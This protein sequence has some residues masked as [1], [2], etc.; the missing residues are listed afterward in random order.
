MNSKR[1]ASPR[2][3]AP[4]RAAGVGPATVNVNAGISKQ[5]AITERV[6]FKVE[7]SF[8]NVFNHTNL[9]DP[10]LNIADSTAGVITSARG[11]DFGGART[12]NRHP[13]ANDPAGIERWPL[14]LD[15]AMDHLVTPGSCSG[16]GA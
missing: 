15:R 9:G 1:P 3:A 11:S 12:V 2:K 7:G 10:E 5:F 16:A 8:T 13:Q 14:R 6:K 4:D